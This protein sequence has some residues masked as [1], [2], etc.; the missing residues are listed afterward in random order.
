MTLRT[1]ISLLGTVAVAVLAIV[2]PVAQGAGFGAESFFASNCEVA[3]CEKGATPTEELENAETEGYSQAS[4]HPPFGITDFKVNRVEASAG[5]FVPVKSLKNLRIDVAPGVSTNPEAVNKCSVEH[6]TSTEVEPVKH[7]FLAPNCPESGSENTVIGENKVLTVLEVGPGVFADVPLS[8]KV[9]NLEQPTGFSSYFG[10]ALQ[11]GAGVFVHTFIEGHVEWGAEA[12]G[13]GK[14]DY[15]DLFEIKNITPG[16]LE[17]RLT[18]KGNIGT[19]GFLSNPSTCSGPGPQTTTRWSGESY[20]AETASLSYTT[21]IGTENCLVVPF[22]P[23]FSLAPETTQSDA[24]D[25]VTTELVL[26]HDP[27]PANLDSSQLK[28]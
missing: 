15:H 17:S 16:L 4:G 3:T 27:N 6:F 19:G 9:Y 28:A 5:L 8:G 1:R 14:A 18:F 22:A 2:V 13:T 12:A 20:E 23:T 10:V 11:V 21:P 7:I 25:G 24:P 26:P